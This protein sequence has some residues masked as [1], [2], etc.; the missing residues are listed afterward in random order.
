MSFGQTATV[1]KAVVHAVKTGYRHLDLAK[2]YQNQHEVGEALKELIPS[3]V[4]R[5]D[6]F[7]TS[8][9]WNNVHKPH[10]IEAGLDDTLKE[11]GTDYLDLYLIHW[12]VPLD[13]GD[14]VTN[15][16]PKGEEKNSKGDAFAKLDL[17]TTLVDT[18]KGLIDLQKKGKVKS[19]G[20]SNFIPSHIEGI[21]KATGVVPAANQIELHPL[22]PQKDL[23]E[24]SKIKGIHVT[25]YSPFGNPGGYGKN[26]VDILGSKQ[27]Q[28]VAKEHGV[29]AGQVLLAWGIQRGYSVIPKSVNP[30]RI[31]NNFKQIK[32]SQEQFEEVSSLIQEHG[33][34]RFNIPIDYPWNINVFNEDSEFKAKHEVNIGA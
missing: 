1:K 29:D 25:A 9:L 12:P 27:V 28:K 30:S 24:Y 7:I 4:K 15:L 13:S 2:I 21:I 3:V 8:K 19:I 32:L 22:L 5:E 16:L 17:K 14:D 34:A 6:L 31:E 33:H 20:V 10:L 11:L 26:G 18:W 23:V